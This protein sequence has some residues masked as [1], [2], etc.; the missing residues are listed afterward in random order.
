MADAA[1]T[2]VPLAAIAV[3]TVLAAAATAAANALLRAV[4][5]AVFDIPEAFEHLALR[6]VVVSSVFGVIAGGLVFALVARFARA[7]VRTF[8]VVATVVL[9][10]SLGAPLSVGLEDPPEYAGTN[11]ESVGTMMAM[12]V[13]AAVIC[14]T[15]VG[16]AWRRAT[17]S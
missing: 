10:A 16:A 12:H 8:A 9:V 5:V 2:P 11:A 15:A 1:R 3:A 7:P 4:A 13:V 14:V 6:A 17:A